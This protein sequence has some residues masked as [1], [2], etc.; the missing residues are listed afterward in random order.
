M[1]IDAMV[2][3]EDFY[4]INEKTLHTYF[5]NTLG[6][7]IKIET[8]DNPRPMFAHGAMV[9]PV[10]NTISNRFPSL[11]VL[12]YVFS[13]FN[14]R[15]NFL[16]YLAGKAYT[17]ASFFTLG[18]LAAKV[19]RFSSRQLPSNVLIW[20]C[21]RKIRIFDFKQNYVDS[22]VKDGFTKKYFEN[23]LS[24]RLNADYSFVPPI[25]NH[26]DNWYREPILPGKPLARI[27]NNL[28]Y[29]LSCNDT[30]KFLKEIVEKTKKFVNCIDYSQS[31]LDRINLLVPLASEKKKI[32]TSVNILSIAKRACQHA[33]KFN[34]DIPVSVSHGDLQ[35]G[36]IWVDV[37]NK[38]TYIIDWETNCYRSIWYDPATLLL[39]IRRHHGVINMVENI[40][41]DLVKNS[42]LIN[43]DRKDYQIESIIGIIILEDIL[44]YLE[45]NL[46]LP[47][48]WGGDLIDK[49]IGQLMLLNW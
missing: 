15:N 6:H 1:K 34:G 39:S 21:N 4:S 18:L 44:F 27:K 45:D 47:M 32:Q 35:S 29:E 37:K 16:K 2:L 12:R 26:G 9:Y 20:P 8:L 10:I 36:N 23:E 38:K 42:I 41:T 5:L 30:L 48:D 14:V 11:K 28:L 17:A 3:R 33:Q 43:D 40:H 24:F 49:Y 22:V 31:L 46:E 19:L 25:L 7:D 13:E